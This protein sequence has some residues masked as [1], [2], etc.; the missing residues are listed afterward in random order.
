MID[1]GSRII[2]RTKDATYCPCKVV[3]MS[4]DNITVRY[5][6]GTQKDR[7]TRESYDNYTVETIPLRH[8]VSMSERI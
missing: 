5:F 3:A 8:V 6:A 2:L 4:N 7:K 1:K